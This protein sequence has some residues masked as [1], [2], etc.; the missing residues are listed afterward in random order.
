MM[1]LDTAQQGAAR[2]M[3]LLEPATRRSLICG[4]V[5]RLKREVHD[6]E[7]VCEPVMR[8]GN[9]QRAFFETGPA[10]REPATTPLLAAWLR[11][12]VGRPRLD[13]NGRPSMGHRY[14]RLEVDVGFP[15]WLP[16][17]LFV[18]MPPAQWGLIVMIRTGSDLFARSMLARWKQ[19][20]GGH[21]SSA[22]LISGNER[23]HP[24]PTEEDVFAACRV[25]WI[26]PVDRLGPEAVRAHSL[27]YSSSGG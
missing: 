23:A 21:S 5:R 1:D 12:G 9:G 2:V 11:D 6:V 4:S 19:V 7:I 26:E 8:P 25:S 20:S 10:S 13:K 14:M 3:R 17:D 22:C 16:V 24:T 27:G 15:V 18:V